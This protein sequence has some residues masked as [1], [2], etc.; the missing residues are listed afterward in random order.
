MI[1]FF[2]EIEKRSWT[3]CWSWATDGFFINTSWK[4]ILWCISYFSW[5]TCCYTYQGLVQIHD[6]VQGKG[7]C[8]R[9]QFTCQNDLEMNTYLGKR[10]L[11]NVSMD[12]N[13]IQKV[14]VGRTNRFGWPIYCSLDNSMTRF[15]GGVFAHLG[16]HR[17]WT[18]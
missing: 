12:L 7:T 13:G 16:I 9:R 15:V 8:G 18:H 5:H 10:N 17:G 11:K 3:T 6:E 14:I 1:F 2:I 4:R